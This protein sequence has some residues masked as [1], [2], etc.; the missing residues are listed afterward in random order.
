MKNQYF[1]DRRDLFKYDLLLDVVESHGANRL[2]FVPML[3]PNDDSG[4]GRLTQSDSR[5]RRVAVFEFLK[6]SLES[7]TRDAVSTSMQ[8]RPNTWPDR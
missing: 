6:G 3:T 4:E 1:G 2:T 7:G 5:G 8:C